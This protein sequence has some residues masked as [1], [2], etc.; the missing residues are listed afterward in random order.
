MD[1]FGNV[2]WLGLDEA[3]QFFGSNEAD[4]FADE[5]VFDGEA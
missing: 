5:P 4:D 3:P 2:D 1:E